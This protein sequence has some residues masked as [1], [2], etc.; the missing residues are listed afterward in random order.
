MSDYH[1]NTTM[2]A[3]AADSSTYDEPVNPASCYPMVVLLVHPL[4]ISLIL[5]LMV[6][7][8][9]SPLVLWENRSAN[10]ILTSVSLAGVLYPATSP[11]RYRGVINV[12]IDKPS[13]FDELAGDWLIASADCAQAH[14]TW[15]LNLTNI[16][17]GDRVV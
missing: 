5:L 6:T 8:I 15:G 12:C 3:A 4:L 9:V 7:V 14:P 13:D 16:N 2:N 1:D 17:A 10:A 11:T